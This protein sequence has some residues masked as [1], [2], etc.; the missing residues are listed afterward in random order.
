MRRA[1]LI[2]NPS[3]GRRRVLADL[4]PAL[5]QTL[6][7]HGISATAL[8]TEGPGT[9]GALAASAAS[10]GADAVFACGG[11][12]TVHAVLQGLVGTNTALGIVPIGTANALARNLGIS[13][14][15]IRAAAQ[16]AMAEPARIPVGKITY[17]R[18]SA[19]AGAAV[20]S[21]YFVV[22]AGAGPD[23]ALVYSL[24]AAQKSALGRAA[25]YAHAARLFLTKAFPPFR[26][27]YRIA[28]SREWH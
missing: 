22:M 2:V 28:S 9:A 18:A 15:P 7:V 5:V 11:D 8:T 25:Y 23:G 26:V 21:R 13:R 6:A 24:L 4:T 1:I 10:N 27:A 12:G 14:D 17:R 3:A 16:Q 19:P 20:A